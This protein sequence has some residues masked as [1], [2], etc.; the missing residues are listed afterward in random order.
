MIFRFLFALTVVALL[1]PVSASANA[2]KDS[3]YALFAKGIHYQGATAELIEVGRWP[4]TSEKVTWR[5]PRI[6]RHT[7]RISLIA[8]QGSGRQMRRWYVPVRVH[9]W[10]DTV[11]LKQE[12][13]LRS[14]LLED[15]LEVKRRDIA[16]HVGVWWSRPSELAGMQVTRPLH[17]GDVIYSSSVKQP[18]LIRRGD[19]V[20]IVARVGSI[21]VRAEGK[22][23]KSGSRGDRLLVQNLRSKQMMQAIVMD[24]NTVHVRTGGAG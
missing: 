16:G 20:T 9:W 14:R 17:K 21:S 2:M 11:V 8:E 22:A 24:A 19:L 6:R 23:L 15:M 3:L 1:M 7:A 12:A 13:P 10:A 5:L 18:P 4:E